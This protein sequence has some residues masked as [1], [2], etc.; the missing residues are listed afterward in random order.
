MQTLHTL[1]PTTPNACR[2][3]A[4]GWLAVATALLLSHAVVLPTP[5]WAGT[6]AATRAALDTFERSALIIESAGKRLPFR[7][8][9]ADTAARREQGLMFVRQ[10]P[11][12]SGM[13]FLFPTTVNTAFWMKNTFI[14]LDL[15]F[16]RSDGSIARIAERA[17]PHDLTPIPSGEPILA[18]L[19]LAGG[20]AALLGLRAGDQV[21]SAA[22]RAARE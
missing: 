15:L 2:Y 18:V 20:T 13:L 11:A 6:T 1:A 10:L 12:N 3:T 8:W 16:I 9:L 14:P 4:Y 22:L 21:V 7:V 5:A 19:E 17:H